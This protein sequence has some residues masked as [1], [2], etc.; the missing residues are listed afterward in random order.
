[1]LLW[2]TSETL[3]LRGHDC[4]PTFQEPWELKRSRRLTFPAQSRPKLVVK[5][6]ITTP[7][8][9]A[10]ARRARGYG[11]GKGMYRLPLLLAGT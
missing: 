8:P 5:P 9:D 2:P 1:M 3:Q 10:M 6:I 4:S 7:T 11:N